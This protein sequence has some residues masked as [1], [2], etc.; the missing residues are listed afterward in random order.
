MLDEMILLI[1]IM[2]VNIV[3][4]GD[5]AIVI[6]M[7]SKHLPLQ[8][9]SQAIWWGTFGAIGLRVVLSIV[10]LLLLQIPWVQFIAAILLFYIAIKLLIANEDHQPLSQGSTLF[11]VIWMI[12][13]ADLI[14]SLDNVLAIAAISAGN[15]IYLVIG[16]TI[17]IPLIIWG[18]GKIIEILHQYPSVI[19]IGSG[20]LGYTAGEMLIRE[21]WLQLALA[22][23]SHLT[24]WFIPTMGALFV[25][26]VGLIRRA[27]RAR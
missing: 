13:I 1:K 4:S 17:S 25:I 20:I 21:Q 27:K 3:L 12:V 2:M 5:N 10:A 22:P 9:R 8:E 11:S 6:A 15:W 7:A 16:V 19:Y 26:S 23:M 18:S 14:M 24:H